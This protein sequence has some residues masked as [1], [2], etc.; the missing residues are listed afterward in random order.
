MQVIFAYYLQIQSHM[1]TYISHKKFHFKIFIHE[2]TC[3]DIN[4][5][6]EHTL[7]YINKHTCIHP[8]S[9][10]RHLHLCTHVPILQGTYLAWTV[11][12]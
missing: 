5:A 1:C 12:R 9:T 7:T 10:H 6:N 8:C 2:H 11:G 4:H 3:T